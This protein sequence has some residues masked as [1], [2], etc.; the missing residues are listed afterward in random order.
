[1]LARVARHVGR[2]ALFGDNIKDGIQVY[3]T[4]GV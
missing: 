4:K 1:M 2:W 3:I